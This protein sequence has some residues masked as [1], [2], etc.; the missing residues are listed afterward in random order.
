MK[1]FDSSTE[2]HHTYLFNKLQ[3]HA[4]L[5]A[6]AT[7]LAARIHQMAAKSAVRNSPTP[8]GQI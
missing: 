5:V 4:L 8:H 1:A 3:T 2:T 6:C 7:M